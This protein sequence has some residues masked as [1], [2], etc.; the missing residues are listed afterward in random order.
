M[1]QVAS[2][3]GHGQIR[4]SALRCGRTYSGNPRQVS[5]LIQLHSKRCKACAN[6]L[7]EGVHINQVEHAKCDYVDAAHLRR[8][9]D[10]SQDCQTRIEAMKIDKLQKFYY[11]QLT[12]HLTDDYVLNSGEYLTVAATNARRRE[13]TATFLANFEALVKK[14]TSSELGSK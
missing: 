2:N 13:K 5:K 8:A 11:H 6:E 1:F 10:F 9:V 7:R 12:T 3:L 4:H 14:A